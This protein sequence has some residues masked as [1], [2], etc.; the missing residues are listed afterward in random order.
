MSKLPEPA[1]FMSVTGGEY[2]GGDPVPCEIHGPSRW[3]RHWL[4]PHIGSCF[5]CPNNRRIYWAFQRNQWWS[6][7]GWGVELLVEGNKRDHPYDGSG[8]AAVCR[9]L[10]EWAGAVEL[11]RVRVEALRGRTEAAA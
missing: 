11:E 6:I 9:T 4:F 3:V 2:V 8:A 1:W 10:D 7:P 5:V